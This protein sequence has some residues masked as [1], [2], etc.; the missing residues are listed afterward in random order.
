[1]LTFY[2]WGK[3]ILAVNSFFYNHVRLNNSFNWPLITPVIC[4]LG[5]CYICI[6]HVFSQR[7]MYMSQ[8]LKIA[9]V[10]LNIIKKAKVLPRKIST[11][12][13]C[14]KNHFVFFNL[15]VGKMH[16]Q[17]Q[18]W[19]F[20]ILQSLC[21]WGVWASWCGPTALNPCSTYGM[22]RPYIWLLVL[23]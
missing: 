8:S 10:T 5:W 13:Q 17:P 4:H 16:F 11:S 20:L 19:H 9:P 18:P 22:H 14:F 2:Q 21:E 1:M 12:Y 23:I 15:I 6:I 3:M 7:K